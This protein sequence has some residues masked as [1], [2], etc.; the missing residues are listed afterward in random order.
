M[1]APPGGGVAAEGAAG[2]FRLRRRARPDVEDADLED[3]A[4]LGAADEDRAGAD[5]DAE[6]LAGA[7]AEERGIHRAGAATVDVLPLRVQ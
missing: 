2:E 6:A 5:V 4:G 7:A 1:V 3:I